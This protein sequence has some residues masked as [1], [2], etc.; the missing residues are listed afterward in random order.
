MK[1]V[2]GLMTTGLLVAACSGKQQASGSGG[3]APTTASAAST[4]T[5]GTGA[6]GAGSGG[7]GTGGS[8]GDVTGPWAG[9]A[10]YYGQWSHGPKSDPSFFPISVWLQSPSSATAF[11]AIGVNTFIG[12]YEGPTQQ[13]LTD[14][15]AAAMPLACDQNT[16]GLANLTDPTI[17]AWTQ[18]DEPDNAQ[19][20]SGGGYG[21]CVPAA[22]IQ[23]L[24]QQMVT[25]DA[26]RP[27]FLNLGQGVAHDYIGWGSACSATH[28]ADYP[29]YVKGGDIVSFD[30]YPMNDTDPQVQGHLELVATGVSN[31]VQWSGG[32]KAVWNWI[33]CTGINDPSGK[34][35]PDEVKAEVWMSIVH[36]SSGIGY[37]VHQ[38]APTFDEK[39]LLDD[40]TMKAAVGAI[41]QQIHDLAPALNTPPIVNG[42]AVSSS[43]TS[44]PV[45]MRLLRQGGSTYILAV[46]MAAGTTTATFSGLTNIP[47]GAA[48]TVLGESRTVPHRRRL[49]HRRLRRLGR[50]LLY[51][52]HTENGVGASRQPQGF[53][54][55]QYALHPSPPARVAVVALLL[56]LAAAV[57][58]RGREGGQ[59]PLRQLRRG[60]PAGSTQRPV[61]G[62]LPRSMRRPSSTTTLA[63]Q[64]PGRR[65]RGSRTSAS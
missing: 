31:L 54:A 36:G 23:M 41:N 19:P 6:G 18:E 2:L 60:V 42:G 9:G 52:I 59:D 20:I 55:K 21:P 16:V 63:S 50:A 51:Q 26:T 7:A 5:S 33:E 25:A 8:N 13:N 4:G 14:L 64:G 61:S 10:G 37:F 44:V 48:V 43:D 17:I 53:S 40:P 56:V 45:D 11:E 28:P 65:S 27:V 22:T 24:Y 62:S 15:A 57:A 34:P 30:I 3:Q 46:A 35:T 1:A 58:A 32:K 49:V 29:D 12:L 39:A 47:A 38:L